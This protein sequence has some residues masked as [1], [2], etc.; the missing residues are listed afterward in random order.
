M[1]PQA[2][3]LKCVCLVSWGKRGSHLLGQLLLCQTLP[4]KVED[5]RELK[6]TTARNF[7]QLFC[8]DVKI[9]T[10]LASGRTTWC[11]SFHVLLPC[12]GVQDSVRETALAAERGDCFVCWCEKVHL[13]K[14][15][16]TDWC[17]TGVQ[18]AFC[19]IPCG[20]W[21]L[22]GFAFFLWWLVCRITLMEKVC[23]LILNHIPYEINAFEPTFQC[24]DC[25]QCVCSS[26][27]AVHLPTDSTC[28]LENQFRGRNPLASPLL[29]WN[30]DDSK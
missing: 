28:N 26:Y 3:P 29:R 9:Y 7:F 11:F 5:D 17:Q 19:W 25:I 1:N 8:V 23:H 21:C 4:T 15:G 2:R 27:S 10:N 14:G 30:I 18:T 6:H 20:L 12:S 16:K 22:Q 13:G 24:C